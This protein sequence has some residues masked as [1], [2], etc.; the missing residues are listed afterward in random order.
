MG[1]DITGHVNSYVEK[2]IT[3]L[4][5][6]LH[7][8]GYNQVDK[9]KCACPLAMETI[10]HPLDVLN[11][12]RVFG[13]PFVR[14]E[15]QAQGKQKTTFPLCSLVGTIVA[16]NSDY[17]KLRKDK[18]SLS[19]AGILKDFELEYLGNLALEL[20]ILNRLLERIIY[21]NVSERS[22]RSTLKFE[23]ETRKKLMK[24]D[25]EI[26]SHYSEALKN[27]EKDH[28]KDGSQKQFLEYLDKMEQTL[29]KDVEFKEPIIKRG[30]RAEGKYAIQALAYV[31][32]HALFTLSKFEQAVGF[33]GALS[34]QSLELRRLRH[35]MHIS[36]ADLVSQNRCSDLMENEATR[37]SFWG[38][39]GRNILNLYDDFIKTGN[40]ES[41]NLVKRGMDNLVTTIYLE[42]LSILV[43][44]YA[45]K[46]GEA[47]KIPAKEIVKRAKLA[48]AL[49]VFHQL[50]IIVYY[51]ENTAG[52][53]K[54][55]EFE[56]EADKALKEE[57]L[58]GFEQIA[59]YNL[60]KGKFQ[61]ARM[62]KL[63]RKI[64]ESGE[65]EPALEAEDI[66]GLRREDSKQ[67]APFRS[68]PPTPSGTA[69]AETA[70][71]EA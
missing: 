3:D 61:A 43:R 41:L 5:T 66:A 57:L 22:S 14:R 51:A 8:K 2:K 21:S 38:V 12:Q 56:A 52:M 65:K 62:N 20:L 37:N 67:E 24:L 15:L 28:G 40:K 10:G 33:K 46:L 44:K 50:A 64:S 59:S 42:I 45:D 63:T 6:K 53:L 23:I 70:P 17:D 54:G 31:C 27:L 47:Y 58:K 1:E 26:K 30:L 55:V 49:S 16:E 35:Q 48:E 71:A 4:K 69:V 13:C 36:A 9:I 7:T 32:P 25:K 29:N 11:T 60:W 68:P 18:D 39:E 19:K 34:G